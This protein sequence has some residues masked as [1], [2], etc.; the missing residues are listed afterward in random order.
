MNEQVQS[1]SSP[2]KEELTHVIAADT[3]FDEIKKEQSPPQPPPYQ[4]TLT[5]MTEED[6]DYDEDSDDILDIHCLY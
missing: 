6:L 4:K 5:G 1:Q 2:P 3:S